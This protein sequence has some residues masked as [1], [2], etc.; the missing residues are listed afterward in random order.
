MAAS[1]QGRNVHLLLTI[2]LRPAFTL[3][4][5]DWAIVML[6]WVMRMRTA[7][8]AEVSEIWLDSILKGD[9]VTELEKLPAASVDVVFADPPYNPAAGG[10]APPPRPVPRSTPSTMTGTS[11]RA[12]PPMMISPAPG[13]WRCAAL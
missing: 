4:G 12:S 2:P 7:R 8:K 1:R 10:Q 5:K 9:C 11:S 13:C 3:F 6:G